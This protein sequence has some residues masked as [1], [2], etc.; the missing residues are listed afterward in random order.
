L[1]SCRVGGE[2]AEPASRASRRDGSTPAHQFH[3]P[4]L[5]LIAHRA[6]L[7]ETVVSW[8]ERLQITPEGGF[9]YLLESLIQ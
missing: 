7:S 9:A 3:L 4:P 6:V 1:E 5:V 8:D 2:D